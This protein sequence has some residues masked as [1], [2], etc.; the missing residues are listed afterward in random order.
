MGADEADLQPVGANVTEL[1]TRTIGATS[2]EVT[3][4]GLGAAPLGNLYRARTDEEA[5]A[6]L[7]AAFDRGIRYV[8][9]A[10][11][12][13]FG[14]GERRV[15][16]AIACRDDIV[17][18][19]KAGRVL[20]PATEE[21]MRSPERH[22]FASPMP[23]EPEFDY[24]RDGILRAFETSLERLGRIDIMYVHDIG[25]LTHGQ[26]DPIYRKQLIEG[27]GLDA[28]SELRNSGAVS[29]IGL[30]VNE[31]AVC[32]DLM[33]V[34]ELDVILL[35][36]RYTLLEQGALD[37]L[38]PRC[39]A[40][41]TSIV[42]GGP[43]NSGI[44]AAGS[45]KAGEAHFDYGP[46]P[47]A[48]RE[49]VA[50]LEAVCAAHGVPLAAAALQFPLAHPAVASVIPGFASEAEVAAGVDFLG[51]PIADGFWRDLRGEHL[52]D[53]R[54]PLPGAGELE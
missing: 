3:I 18:S 28:L 30:G 40:A 21:E 10:P 9:T 5:Q 6:T 39:L 34:A 36:G 53:E 25:R 2:L 23:F 8:D 4:L 44:L 26:S 48:I 37:E 22:G 13:G 24:S 46:V 49:R 20:R 41:G 35:A 15:G 42:V 1:P 7:D 54:A 50:K 52:V 12:Y 11:Y 16:E 31:I 38:F 29:A 27:G 19:T 33:D 32:L 14:L 17:V 45:A 47:P 43:F 51:L